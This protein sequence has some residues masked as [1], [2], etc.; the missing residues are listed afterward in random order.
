MD[1]ELIR[2]YRYML[3][4][5]YEVRYADTAV[6]GYFIRLINKSLFR[7]P[8]QAIRLIERNDK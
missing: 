8:D 7:W 1:F 5:E 6:G 4:G 3:S 2:L